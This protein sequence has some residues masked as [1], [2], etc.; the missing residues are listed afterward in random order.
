[1]IENKEARKKLISTI[2]DHQR[3][4]NEQLVRMKK[5]DLV[6]DPESPLLGPI[7]QYAE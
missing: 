6:P 5:D 4:F 7:K 2:D 1:M 3:V